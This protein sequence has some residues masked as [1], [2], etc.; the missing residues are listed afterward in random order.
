MTTVAGTPGPQPPA[1]NGITGMQERVAALGGELYA[2]PRPGGGF[3]VCARL[4]VNG[5]Q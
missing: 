5:T 1:S 2:G 4:P 3:R